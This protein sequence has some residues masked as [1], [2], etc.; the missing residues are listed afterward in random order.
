MGTGVAY[1]YSVV[2]TLRRRCFRRP[3][4][5]MHGAVAVYFEAAAVI[6]VLVL[7]GQVLELRARAQTSGAIRALLGLAPKTAR[8][9]HE[10]G[11][12]E[13]SPSTPSRS[14]ICCACGPARRCRSMAPS[15]EGSSLVDESDGHR[16]VDAGEKERRRAGDRRHRQPE[17]QPCDARREGRPRHHAGAHR[18]IW[19]REAQRSRA[20]VQRLADQV[21]GWFVPV[22][23]A[24]ALAGVRGMGGVRPR[25]ALHLRAGRRGDGADHRLSLRA[26]AC[27]ADVD[28]GR[29]RPRR[30][31][32]AFSF[33]NAE[34]LERM[35]KVDTLVIDKTGTLTEGK[36]K[37][38]AV[39]LPRKESTD[40]ELLRLAAQRRARAASIRWPLRSSNAAKERR[41]RTARRSETSTRP[42]ARAPAARSMA[43]GV[44]LGNA[45]YHAASSTSSTRRRWKPMRAPSASD[46]ATAIYSGGGWPAPPA[47]S[48]LPIRSS[49]ARRGR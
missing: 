45:A 31:A 35:E 41:H 27:D 36:P 5:I 25:A 23:I 21:A 6:T 28:H 2:A 8:R 7:L 4:A 32:R 33:E 1:V 39:V 22:V 9:D 46:G 20:P 24:V 26:R 16:R 11:D 48:P 3:S 12:E 49:R 17:R 30:R 14:A 40:D 44:V 37:V 29:R 10:D 15:T 18:A 19:W 38:V 47:S 34:A 43:A 42:P 13:A